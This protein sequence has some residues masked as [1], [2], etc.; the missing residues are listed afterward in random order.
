MYRLIEAY[1]KY[2]SGQ[3]LIAISEG[4]DWIR[5]KNG[6]YVPKYLLVEPG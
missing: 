4:E 2:K 5:T 6:I 3:Q 1:W